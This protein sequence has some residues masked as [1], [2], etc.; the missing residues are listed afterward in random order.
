MIETNLRIVS[1][2]TALLAPV[3]YASVKTAHLR[4]EELER[5]CNL[6]T[7]TTASRL[8]RSP[9]ARTRLPSYPRGRFLPS[10]LRMRARP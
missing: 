1:G 6:L 3:R 2:G 7:I 8:D 4:S 10:R 9:A 5:A